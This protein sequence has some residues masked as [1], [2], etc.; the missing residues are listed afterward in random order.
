MNRRFDITIVGAGMTGLGLAALL[1]GDS[2][3]AVRVIDA[4]PQ[5]TFDENADVGLRVSALAPATVDLLG[6]TGAWQ[7]IVDRRA[8]PYERM[9]VWDAGAEPG[10]PA[11]VTFDANEFAV[12]ELGFI[13]E[14]AFAMPSSRRC[15]QAR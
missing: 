11:T 12:A 7:R 1:A 2:R 3:C 8:S 14:N 6:R 10:G 5:P 15:R 9:Q 13:V 4:G